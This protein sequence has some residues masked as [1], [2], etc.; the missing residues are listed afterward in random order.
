MTVGLT[1]RVSCIPAEVPDFDLADFLVKVITDLKTTDNIRIGSRAPG[2]EDVPYRASS[3]ATI[4]IKDIPLCFQDGSDRWSF[5][6]IGRVTDL[7]VDKH[8][9][10]FTPLND[11]GNYHEL[12]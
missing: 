3:I 1:F 9:D 8:F 12:E 7:I 11:V 6:I 10:G 5:P 4:L 2:L